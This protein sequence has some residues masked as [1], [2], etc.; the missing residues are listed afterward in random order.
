M[1][2]TSGNALK[3]KVQTPVGQSPKVLFIS[4][5]QLSLLLAFLAL[6]T[7]FVQALF[8][9]SFTILGA[10]LLFGF[11]GVL[12]PR[13]LGTSAGILY[14]TVFSVNVLVAII[15]YYIYLNNY[16]TPYYYGGSDDTMFELL[17]ARTANELEI[18]QYSGIRETITN[19]YYEPAGYVY[20]VS[21]L[22][23]LGESWGGF[24]TILPRFLNAMSLGL[25]SVVTYRIATQNGVQ[26]GIAFYTALIVGVLPIMTFNAAHTFRDVFVSLMAILTVYHWDHALKKDTQR[27]YLIVCLVTAFTVRI[28]WEFRPMQAILLAILAGAAYIFLTQR[29]RSYFAPVHLL[30][31]AMFAGVM[32]GV[33]IWQGWF[34]WGIERTTFYA[35]Y[36]TEYRLEAS[37]GIANYIFSAPLPISIVLRFIYGLI[38]PLPFLG[39][40]F[41]EL[42]QGAGTI[43]HYFFLPFLLLG[44]PISARSVYGR[45]WIL[46]FALF[47]SASLF[48]F[49]S[50]HIVIFLPYAALITA[51]GYIVYKRYSLAIALALIWLAGMFGAIY[52]VLKM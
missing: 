15:I 17:A 35:D 29:R 25:I 41:E 30:T 13:K 21:L 26:K 51:Q 50:R 37:S 39:Q 18:W 36:Y 48:T 38:S 43:V 42:Y 23:R 19:R 9:Q 20:L 8:E 45:L 5:T 33:T 2:Q 10:Y 32:I 7:V 44:I 49:T 28:M 11:L 27:G 47:Y 24:H 46:A 22:Y 14:V 4:G 6:G 34:T 3:L 16:G 1:N 31:I 12:W 52:I 40:R